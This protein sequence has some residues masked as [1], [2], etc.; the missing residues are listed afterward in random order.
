[1][2]KIAARIFSIHLSQAKQY[3]HVNSHFSDN[4]QGLNV[5]VNTACTE[6]TGI[7]IESK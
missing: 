4:T 6:L 5:G 3:S 2:C 1:M 7:S